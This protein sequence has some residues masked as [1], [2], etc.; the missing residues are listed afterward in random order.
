MSEKIEKITPYPITSSVSV[1]FASVFRLASGPIPRYVATYL[2]SRYI[3]NGIRNGLVLRY[4]N[5]GRKEFTVMLA[6]SRKWLKRT[7]GYLVT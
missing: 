4:I 2:P 1:K 7:T 3:I 6:D 5:I